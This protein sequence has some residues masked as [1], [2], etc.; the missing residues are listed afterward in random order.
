MERLLFFTFFGFF[1]LS[2]VAIVSDTTWVIVFIG[3]THL[4]LASVVFGWLFFR[5]LREEDERE[6]PSGQR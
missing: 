1:V 6:E 3:V 2:M 4:V 5:K